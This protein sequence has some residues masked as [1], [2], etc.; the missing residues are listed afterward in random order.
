[1]VGIQFHLIDGCEISIVGNIPTDIGGGI[2]K[3]NFEFENG[4]HPYNQKRGD[5]NERTQKYF[6]FW[7]HELIIQQFGNNSCKHHF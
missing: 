6:A 3:F 4:I 7:G 2:R 5:D 1:M